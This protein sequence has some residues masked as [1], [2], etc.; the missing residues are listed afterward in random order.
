MSDNNN[1]I[2]W[3]EEEVPGVPKFEETVDASLPI[4]D[5][6]GKDFKAL[7]KTFRSDPLAFIENPVMRQQI[8]Q[9]S[10]RTADPETERKK[11]AL[12]AFFSVKSKKDLRFVK[13][14]IDDFLRDYYGK[15]TGATEAYRKIAQDSYG[16]HEDVSKAREAVSSGKADDIEAALLGFDPNGPLPEP[17]PLSMKEGFSIVQRELGQRT[18]DEIL[19]KRARHALVAGE[20]QV[21]DTLA[22]IVKTLGGG[23]LGSI[24]MDAN[25]RLA[26]VAPEAKK[27]D[28]RAPYKAVVKS[29]D[30]YMARNYAALRRESIQGMRLPDNW[31]TSSDGLSDWVGNAVIAT[32]NYLPALAA[33]TGLT[34]FGGVVPLSA[35]FANNAYYDIK[36]EMPEVSEGKAVAYSLGIGLINGAL[37]KVSLGILQNKVT[38]KYAVEGVK[39]GLLNA[40]KYFGTDAAFESG[41]EFLEQ[42]SENLLDIS[43]GLRGDPAKWNRKKWLSE[44]FR[45]VPEASVT[46]FLTSPSLSAVGYGS[47]RQL[48]DRNNKLRSTLADSIDA[49]KAKENPTPEERALLKILQIF[50]DAGN[51]EDVARELDKLNLQEMIRQHENFISGSDPEAELDPDSPEALEADRDHAAREYRR[52]HVSLRHNP[53]DT[54]DL[55]TEYSADIPG[56]T[57][58]TVES[59]D[60]IKEILPPDAPARAFTDVNS[61]RVYINTG[62]VRPSEVLEVMLHEAVGHQGLRAVVPEK[63]LDRMLDQVYAQHLNDE[64]FQKV[65]LRYF[66]EKMQEIPDVDGI[67][68][69][70]VL[71]DVADQ[72]LAAEEYLAY[73]AGKHRGQQSKPSWWREFIQKVRMWFANYFG[74]EF[75]MDDRQI[76]TLLARAARK[77]SRGKLSGQSNVNSEAAAGEELRFSVADYSEADERDIINILKPFVGHAA[78]LTD[79][80]YKEYLQKYGVDIPE[81]DAWSFAYLAMRENTA[82]ARR[83]HD[84]IRDN[85]LYENVLEYQWAVSFAGNKNF[86]LKISPRFAT[87]EKQ[88]TFWA[89]KSDA[90]DS[91]IDLEELAAH[92]AREFGMDELDVEQQLFDFY[93][94]LKKPDLYKVYKQ[95]KEDS[96]MADKEA[97]R[98]AK[99]EW[100]AV[101]KAEVEDAVVEVLQRGQPISQDWIFANRDVYKELYRQLF[102][103]KAAPYAPGKKDLEAVNAAI[104][105]EGANAAT[106]AQAYKDAREKAW[107]AYQDKLRQLR[108]KVLA[109]KADAVKLQREAAAFAAKELARENRGEF[110]R[111]IIKLLDYSTQPNAKY[112]MGKRRAE[113]EKLLERM[114]ARAAD[115]R[116]QNA[117]AKIHDLLERNRSRRTDKN[118]PYSPMGERQGALDRINQISR[119]NPETV[120]TLQAF[121]AEQVGIIQEQLDNMMDTGEDF[122]NQEQ[123]GKLRAEL[124]KYENDLFYLEYFGN[125]ALKTPDA[126]E[127]SLAMLEKFIKS[128]RNEFLTTMQERSARIRREREDLRLEMTKGDLTVPDRRTLNTSQNLLKNFVLSGLSDTQL[129]REFSRI[130][131]DVEFDRSEHGK[132]LRMIEDSS[133]AEQ[134]WKREVQEKLNKFFHK[135]DGGNLIERGKFLRSLTQEENTGV[136]IKFYG[137]KLDAANQIS[138]DPELKITYADFSKGRPTIKADLVLEHTRKMLE[139]INSGVP[140]KAVLKV[141]GLDN[142]KALYSDLRSIDTGNREIS[143]KRYTVAVTDKGFRVYADTKN[144][145]VAAFDLDKPTPAISMLMQ[146][147]KNI[148]VLD[149]IAIAA[150]SAR[151]REFD[152]GADIYNA[153]KSGDEV[154]DAA[155]KAYFASDGKSPVQKVRLVA[156]DPAALEQQRELVLSPEQAV[157]IILTAEQPNYKYNMDFNGFTSDKIAALKKFL[158]EKHPGALELG[159]TMREIVQAQRKQLDE[160]VF[161]RYGVHLP[162]QDNFWYADFG[163]SVTTNIQDAGFGNSAGGMTVSANFLTARRF[164]TLPVATQSGFVKIF[165]RKQLETAH[166]VAW[167]KTVRELRSLYGNIDVQNVLIKEFGYDAWLLWKKR[168][169]LLATGGDVSNALDQFLNNINQTFFPANIALNLKSVASQLA[170]GVAYALYVPP[171][172]LLSRLNINRDSE[173]YRRFIGQVRVSGYLDNRAGG[174]FDP[175]LRSITNPYTRKSA[176]PMA[177]ALLEKSLALTTW[178]DAKGAIFWGFMAYDYFYDQ[179]LKRELDEKAA[180]DFAFRM[181]KRATD[182]TQ[183]SGA[184][185]DRN[186]FNINAGALRALTAYMTS[187][188]QQL[189]LEISA[190]RKYAKDRTPENRNEMIRRIIVNH[191]AVTTSMN[192]IAAAFRH[193]INFGDYLDDWEDFVAGWL[194]GNLDAVWIF[195]K[196][197]SGLITGNYWQQQPKSL[198]PAADNILRDVNKIKKDIQG[199]S[200]FEL[201]DYLQAA[202]DVLMSAGPA[203]TRIAGL[204]LFAAAREIRRFGRMFDDKAAK[205]AAKEA[206]KQRKKEEKE[207]EKQR[208]KEEQE[209][210]KM[211]QQYLKD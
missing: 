16:E 207:A 122:D 121:A 169:E 59:W 173:R 197:I 67:R 139:D 152:A 131:D 104:V 41:S 148:F 25:S 97:E 128:G 82:A 45:G 46:A 127:K 168:I 37:E 165:M 72:R 185:K 87:E 170:G 187:P 186:S 189:G 40:A 199:K 56:I 141:G 9:E 132:V 137:R 192:L 158:Q 5:F 102:D 44:M 123:A 190:I 55:V 206:E 63:F 126:A 92:V 211:I 80:E 200:E 204:G 118:V 73:L 96:L 157:Q 10:A 155:M 85:W 49:L 153:G 94:D 178:S 78:E 4:F 167:S 19:P 171:Q 58:V 119:M 115:S 184:M 54:A 164:H 43:M 112:P 114:T 174:G 195:G 107:S 69:E 66:P 28:T 30:N 64:E 138:D 57:F 47:T 15:E 172:E 91:V 34:L 149:D 71:E 39:A 177:D 51:T 98:A 103:G 76:E 52:R 109:N 120:L 100:M 180:A 125:L 124:E 156:A 95:F 140:V 208:K 12:A 42:F 38:K 83:K 84:S 14:N 188:M 24:Y 75:I 53:Q 159:Y 182:E 33:Q 134:T 27:L 129:V 191:F 183:Q 193:G 22:N 202:G 163:G 61:N 29:V 198:V 88:G 210:R 99:E 23:I 89:K 108:E 181:W 143:G 154:D 20:I 26:I 60:H 146:D 70:V 111:G 196:S 74:R 145:E 8:Y 6:N 31:V 117:V 13:D 32:V 48:N 105:Q 113:F 142:A 81:K 62:K 136:T 144:G 166:F 106:Y 36:A 161:E 3:Y 77:V 18:L 17:R 205:A 35:V 151:I 93:K 201:L 90:G 160:A 176:S 133:E 79:R 101:K 209:Y 7:Q 21:A 68:T 203:Y 135:N 65:L 150:G 86:K 11:W 2:P 50:N 162:Q 1:V 130:S 116:R 110:I 179:A 175:S 147:K 194:L